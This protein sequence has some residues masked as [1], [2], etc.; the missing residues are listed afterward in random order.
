MFISAYRGFT[1]C[2]KPPVYRRA[3]RRFRNLYSDY[4]DPKNLPVATASLSQFNPSCLQSS[5]CYVTRRAFP[6]RG[7]NWERPDY[8]CMH[9]KHD[10]LRWALRCLCKWVKLNMAVRN[11]VGSFNSHPLRTNQSRVQSQF[12]TYTSNLSSDSTS[13]CFPL[14]GFNM[15]QVLR[16]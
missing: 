16:S 12:I 1:S 5:T 8:W 13:I 7:S 11:P 3:A 4:V 15:S 14:Q 2:H 6:G 10:P 9:P